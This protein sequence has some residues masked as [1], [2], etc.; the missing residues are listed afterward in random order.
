MQKEPWDQPHT[1]EGREALIRLAAQYEQQGLAR[2]RGITL[3]RLARML[4]WVGSGRPG[5]GEF[6]WAAELGQ[7]AVELLR[8]TDDRLA[9]AGALRAAAQPLVET[10][11]REQLLREALLISKEIG[12][13]SGEGWAYFSLAVPP[14]E[15]K[16]LLDSAA[17]CFEECQDRLGLAN[18][19]QRRG[20]STRDPKLFV[21]AAETF[22]E[23]GR[24]L[25]AY[26]AFMMAGVFAHGRYSVEQREALFLQ[27]LEV[28]RSSDL[29]AEQR[30]A[31]KSLADLMELARREDDR[32]NYR[33]QM[34]A[35]PFES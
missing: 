12:D 14:A 7:Q 6:E 32:A 22:T 26:R 2:E 27:A 13:L 33:A 25:D 29:V 35:I 15:T 18:V 19:A 23:L 21:N 30:E 9:L 24:P 11:N 10:G 16:P 20:A 5:V 31:L 3:T 28:A 17:A 8:E 34:E 4:K 1:A